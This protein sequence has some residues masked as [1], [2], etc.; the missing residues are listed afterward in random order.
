MIIKVFLNI[1]EVSNWRQ[2]CALMIAIFIK[3]SMNL[4]ATKEIWQKNN[5]ISIIT[6]KCQRQ[7]RKKKKKNNLFIKGKM[8]WNFAIKFLS[9]Y[10]S[11]TFF[12]IKNCKFIGFVQFSL[13][14]VFFSI[15][16]QEQL[17]FFLSSLVVSSFWIDSKKMNKQEK[18][19][20]KRYFSKLL[21]PPF[22]ILSRHV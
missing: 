10:F 9:W 15:K 18:Y 12:I 14:N 22:F 3:K 1:S 4:F 2:S 8:M 21:L 16:T 19:L 5:K 17:F 7:K 11:G 20:I 6:N 13:E